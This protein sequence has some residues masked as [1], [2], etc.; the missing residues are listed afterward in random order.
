MLAVN[1][2]YTPKNSHWNPQQIYKKGSIFRFQ[3]WIL[4]W[5]C[6]RQ[7]HPTT[8]ISNSK[9]LLVHFMKAMPW[10]MGHGSWVMTPTHVTMHVM[11][12]HFFQGKSLQIYHLNC[13]IPPPKVIEWSPFLLESKGGG[14]DYV[15]V[16]VNLTWFIWNINK[17]G[18]NS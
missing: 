15:I 18:K 17:V 7:H 3:A 5:G 1:T 9:V 10:G 4:R 13:F 14:W 12:R 16:R 11:F 8:M 6:W 2:H